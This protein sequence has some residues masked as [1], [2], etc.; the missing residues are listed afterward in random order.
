MAH[1]ETKVLTGLSYTKD[2]EWL[3][4]EG[5]TTRLGVSDFAQDSM[6]DVVFVELPEVGDEFAEGDVICTIESVKAVSEVY[7]PFD[8]KIIATNEVL[9]DAPETINSDAFGEGWLVD[10]EGAVADAAVLSATEYEEF[11]KEA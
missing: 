7:A 10:V 5:A 6:G 1:G 3:K 9:L 2:H 8:C 4:V 11:I